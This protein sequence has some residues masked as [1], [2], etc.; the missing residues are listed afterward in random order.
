MPC[1]TG[2]EIVRALAAGV[3]SLSLLYAVM[4]VRTGG[5]GVQVRAIRR[6]GAA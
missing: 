4:D 5:R 3:L 6:R 2:L 1:L